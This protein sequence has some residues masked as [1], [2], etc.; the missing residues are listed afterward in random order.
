MK[1]TY[2][3]HFQNQNS[4]NISYFPIQILISKIE[5]SFQALSFDPSNLEHKIFNPS[6]NRAIFFEHF[7]LDRAGEFSSDSS[8]ISINPML[9][10]NSIAHVLQLKFWQNS[11]N[12]PSLYQPERLFSKKSLFGSPTNG[13]TPL[14]NVVLHMVL[15]QKRHV[16]VS[17]NFLGR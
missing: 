6:T 11:G 15:H 4:A 5:Q 7:D 2:F 17:E 16:L 3:S 1:S 10:L 12:K 9:G 14:V 13:K 8:K